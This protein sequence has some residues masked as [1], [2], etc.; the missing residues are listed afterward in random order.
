MVNPF[1]L[2][3]GDKVVIERVSGSENLYTLKAI[4]WVSSYRPEKEFLYNVADGFLY[5]MAQIN[6]NP[7]YKDNRNYITE[8]I[9]ELIMVAETLQ[10]EISRYGSLC[11]YKG[12]V[13]PFINPDLAEKYI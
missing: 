4:L 11:Y 12:W 13:S 2:S 3:F 5:S 6:G 7:K 9:D 10:I 1:K 8:S